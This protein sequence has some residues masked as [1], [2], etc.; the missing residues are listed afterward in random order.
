MIRDGQKLAQLSD[1][2]LATIV[3]SCI[4]MGVSPEDIADAEAS[5]R[6]S[7]LGRQMVCKAA[8]AYDCLAALKTQTHIIPASEESRAWSGMEGGHRFFERPELSIKYLIFGY[9]DKVVK[10]GPGRFSEAR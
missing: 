10:D 4:C 8:A 2:Q 3:A 1:K 6:S 5:Y 9:L 7:R